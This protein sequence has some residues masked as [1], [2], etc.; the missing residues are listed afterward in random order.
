MAS[1][2]QPS[3]PQRGKKSSGLDRSS[4]MAFAFF[5]RRH[6]SSVSLRRS[7]SSV[8]SRRHSSPIANNAEDTIIESLS[9]GEESAGSSSSGSKFPRALKWRLLAR[10]VL[11]N[12]EEEDAGS[13]PG[14]ASSDDGNDVIFCILRTEMSFLEHMSLICGRCVKQLW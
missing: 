11:G 10:K 12:V 5:H 4:S 6:S 14:V 2:G 3:R 13:N 7:V 9:D 1:S 8:S